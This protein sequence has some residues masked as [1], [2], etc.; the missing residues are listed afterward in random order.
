MAGIVIGLASIENEAEFRRRVRALLLAQEGITQEAQRQ[1]GA[2]TEELQV[3]PIRKRVVD[4]V[5]ALPEVIEARRLRERNANESARSR[6]NE[7]VQRE[8]T[9]RRSNNTSEAEV[10]EWRD[11]AERGD[12]YA[13]MCLGL[14]YEKGEGV[15]QN[16]HEAVK[17]YRKAAEQ[18]LA[19][20]QNNLGWLY[21]RG[22][23]VKQNKAE[24][25]KWYRKAAKQ[26]LATA[27][28][29]LGWVYE[30]GE[31]VK[32]NKAE[33]VKWYRKA[34]KQGLA[35]AQNSLGHAYYF[36]EG[37][38]QDIAAAARWFRRAAKQGDTDAPKIL[39]EIGSAAA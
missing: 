25:V 38:E 12:T 11:K 6:S 4:E 37:V 17:W 27:Q 26:G 28:N 21:E 5:L 33:A 19:T 7:E 35:T 10:K 34:A 24:A 29:N 14:A 20:A 15:E 1:L 2:W 8:N 9:A 32:Q 23:G 16:K 13:Q 22:K 3:Q 36:G 30:S 39:Q 31:G 18:G